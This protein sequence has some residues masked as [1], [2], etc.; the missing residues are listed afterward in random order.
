MCLGVT[1]PPKNSPQ[2]SL[3]LH[4]S[5]SLLARHAGDRLLPPARRQSTKPDVTGAQPS[6]RLLPHKAT[7][8][9]SEARCQIPSQPSPDAAPALL[10]DILSALVPYLFHRDFVAASESLMWEPSPVD[11]PSLL[12]G[13]LSAHLSYLFLSPNEE[14][15]ER[16]EN[17]RAKKRGGGQDVAEI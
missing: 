15:K 1:K 17:V 7:Q 5:C 6:Y 10:S 11:A 12:L 16:N 13:L 2:N 9:I 14:K 8:F 3:V 4:H